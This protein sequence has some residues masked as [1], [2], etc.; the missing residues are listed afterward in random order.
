MNA[1]TQWHCQFLTLI[2]IELQGQINRR[3][4]CTRVTSLL[5]GEESLRRLP[6]H[7]V[8][9]SHRVTIFALTHSYRMKSYRVVQDAIKVSH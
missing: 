3:V 8:A 2:S 1:K 6:V 9:P 4:S 7:H 5:L